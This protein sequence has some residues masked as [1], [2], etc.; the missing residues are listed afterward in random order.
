MSGSVRR[1]GRLQVAMLCPFVSAF[2][3]LSL[4]RASFAKAKNINRAAPR[5]Y[6]KVWLSCSLRCAARAPKRPAYGRSRGPPRYQAPTS[7]RSPL[8]LRVEPSHRA[9]ASSLRVTGLCAAFAPSLRYQLECV[10]ICAS[11]S[12]S[13]VARAVLRASDGLS[14]VL[15]AEVMPRRVLVMCPTTQSQILNGRRAAGCPGLHMVELRKASRRTMPTVIGDKRAAAIVANVDLACDFGRYTA[16]ARC[17][18]LCC[19]GFDASSAPRLPAHAK[20][21]LSQLGPIRLERAL[22]QR[23]ELAPRLRVTSQRAYFFLQLAEPQ[24][25]RAVRE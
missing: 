8:S 12:L 15:S 6:A 3:P 24:R 1:P 19:A 14:N 23:Q 17:G 18:G 22:H 13:A 2:G 20:P 25:L 16:R 9:L 7:R 5:Q 11:P 21:T 4:R 10:A